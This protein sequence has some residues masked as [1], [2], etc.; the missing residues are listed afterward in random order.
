MEESYLEALNYNFVNAGFQSE[1]LGDLKKLSAFGITAKEEA[2]SVLNPLNEDFAVMRTSLVP[3]LVKNVQNNSRH[4]RKS[5]RLFEIGYAFG[6]DDHYGQ[7][8]RLGLSVWGEPLDLWSKKEKAPLALQ[9]KASV[10]SLLQ[11]LRARSW[12]WIQGA[13]APDFLHPGRSASLF[14]E[15]KIIGFV[16]EMHPKW[17]K[18]LKIKEQVCLAEFQLDALLRGQP[19]PFRVSSISKMPK[20]DRD[21]AFVCD[22]EVKASDIIDLIKKTAGKDL[23]SVSVFDQFEGGS[24]EPGQKSLAFRM[25]FQ[26]E[27][28]TLNDESINKV[29]EKIIDTVSKKLKASVR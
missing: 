28:E 29:Q 25:Y 6:R 13:D 17:K 21:L 23:K 3:G 1:F 19:K 4:G 22:S 9:L 5:G 15:G 8:A 7:D 11:S 10:D 16:G 2:V 20:V 12:S 18:Q 24:L 27:K 26:S 14:F